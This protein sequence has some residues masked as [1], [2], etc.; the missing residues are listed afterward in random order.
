MNEGSTTKIT[1]F[2]VLKKNQIDS[3]IYDV[4][5]TYSVYCESCQMRHTGSEELPGI[6][7]N[8]IPNPFFW[9]LEKKC[10]AEIS[11]FIS[12]MILKNTPKGMSSNSQLIQF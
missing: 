3:P 2:A 5:S 9:K 10:V 7:K 6:A 8:F 12:E 4:F 1:I 11:T